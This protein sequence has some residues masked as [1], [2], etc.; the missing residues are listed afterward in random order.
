MNNKVATGR[1]MRL[2]AAAVVL[3]MGVQAHTGPALADTLDLTDPAQALKATRKLYCS[4]EDGKPI[5][6]QWQGRAY[7]RV[8]GER[9]RHLFNVLGMNVRAC[10]TV[11]D[12]DRGEGFR[13]VSREIMLY[14]DPETN[15]VLR[16]WSNPWTGADVEVL[17]VANDPVNFRAPLFPVGRDGQPYRF[18]GRTGGGKVFIN[19]EVPLFYT[20]PLAGDFQGAAGNHYH[21]MEMFNFIMD[22]ADLIDGDKDTTGA[23]VSWA[24]VAQWLPWMQMGSR[25]GVMVFNTTGRKLESWDGLEQVLKDEIAANY[26]DYRRPPPADD[27]RP[28]ETSWTYYKKIVEQRRAAGN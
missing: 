20:N 8:P 17:H 23:V 1:T 18:P 25:P 13:L 26:P 22:E 4:L 15:D 5:T 28:N 14:L 7:S 2:M 12:A 27:A 24:R 10:S 16:R 21:A 6:Y 11:A 19:V 9:D 3:G